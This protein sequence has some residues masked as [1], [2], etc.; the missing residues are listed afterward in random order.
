[1]RLAVIVPWGESA[2]AGLASLR[3]LQDMRCSGHRIIIV[4]GSGTAAAA[5]ALA[6]RIVYAPAGWA[7]QANAGSRAPEAETAD[8]LLFVAP[9]VQL[10]PRAG[11]CIARALAAG[12]GPWGRF[13][14]QYRH[15]R[16]RWPVPLAVAAAWSNALARWTGLC[17]R[18]QS[19]FVARGAFLAIGGFAPVDPQRDPRGD[20]TTELEFSRWARRL[21]RPCVAH[22][23]ATVDAPPVDALLPLL[24]GLV[25][26]EARRLHRAT[27][28]LAERAR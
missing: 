22:G 12:R 25:Q 2:A 16:G 15:A 19:I 11:R 24:R 4:D 1:M 13:N 23:C 26:R 14:V 10:P 21:G 28:A 9:G 17:T 6:D 3:A 5:R 27:G 8:A 20:E 18:E 7:R